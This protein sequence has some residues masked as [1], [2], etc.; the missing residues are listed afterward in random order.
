MESDATFST[1]WRARA[2]ACYL[3]QFHRTV[4]NDAWWEPGYTEWTITRKMRPMFRGHAQPLVPGEL[5]YYDLLDADARSAQ[6]ELARRHGIEGFCYWHY[7]SRGKRLLSRPFDE[8]LTSGQP[9]FPFCLGWANH[10][11]RDHWVGADR[12]LWR[13]EY[14]G[15]DDEE[16][17][18]RFLAA[19]FADTRY[20]RVAGR[21]LFVVHRPGALPDGWL[22]R[23]NAFVTARGQEEV[24]SVAWGQVGALHGPLPPG[25]RARVAGEAIYDFHMDWLRTPRRGPARWVARLRRLRG[26]PVRYRQEAWNRWLDALPNGDDILPCCLPRWDNTPRAHSRG[27]LLEA[28]TAEGF[29]A[30]VRSALTRLETRPPEQRVL[31]VRSWNE[32]GQGNMLEPDSRFGR[33]FLEALRSV[34]ANEREV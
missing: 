26:Q 27:F 22:D 3:P 31:F 25:F 23:L 18:F 33:G 13:Q 12:E 17:H 19:A 8:V 4:E 7:W 14:G 24:E 29:A 32:W 15:P 11:W 34:L 16:A 1:P 21:P 2:I 5:G 20:I 28:A 10:D 9:D 30:Q 6:A